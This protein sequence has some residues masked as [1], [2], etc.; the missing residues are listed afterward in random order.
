MGQGSSHKHLRNDFLKNAH[1]NPQTGVMNPPGYG[2]ND[3][4][5]YQPDELIEDEEVS[6]PTISSRNSY[7]ITLIFKFKNLNQV[8]AK[9]NL[10]KIKIESI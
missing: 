3:Y 9:I 4:S 7:V 8:C 2:P 10:N 5:S 6:C 1:I